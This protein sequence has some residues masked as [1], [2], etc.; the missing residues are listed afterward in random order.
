M[1]SLLTS[2]RSKRFVRRST[3]PAF[4]LTARDL[5]L[6]NHVARHCF[7]SSDNLVK[8]DGGSAQNVL[9][10]LRVLFD[11]QYLDRPVAQLNYV[12]ATGPQPL[13][14]GLC[15]RG[16]R[17]LR[18]QGSAPSDTDWTER[19]KRAGAKYIAHSLA[20]AEFM[21]A[22]EVA[23][24]TQGSVKLLNEGDI[25]ARAPAATRVSRSGSSCP[26]SIRSW[27]SRPSCP[28]VYPDFSS[29]M[30]ARRTFCWRSTAARC[31][32]FGRRLTKRVFSGSSSYTGRHGKKGARG[33]FRG[34][35]SQGAYPN[36]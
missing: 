21:V 9:R 29:R 14:Y 36:R 13:V 23:C 15:R 3:P 16:A 4:Q 26:A 32:C 22:L 12:P 27:V 20:I 18:E 11:H 5:K 31:L 1:D 8:L 10:S 7:L 28:T 6:L 25:L 34:G 24:A 33:S 17:A 35:A 30:G 19:N 2:P